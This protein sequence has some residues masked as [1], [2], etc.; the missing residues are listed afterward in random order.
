MQVC[1]PRFFVDGID[2]AATFSVEVALIAQAAHG[3]EIAD[4]R[5]KEVE[6][7]EAGV[8]RVFFQSHSEV[9]TLVVEVGNDVVVVF[10]PHGLCIECFECFVEAFLVL[11]LR[12]VGFQP[13]P[14]TS[15]FQEVNEQEASR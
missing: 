8:E 14:F 11:L 9:S 10:L 2:D 12:M 5:V 4:R 3:F 15:V 6:V 13:A 1:F 7:E